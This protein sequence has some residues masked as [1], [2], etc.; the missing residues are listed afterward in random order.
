MLHAEEEINQHASAWAL[1]WLGKTRLW[2]VPAKPDV[3]GRLFALWRTSPDA[4][5]REMA[6]WALTSQT[7][8]PRDEQECCASVPLAELE[9]LLQQYKRLDSSGKVAL[10]LV[11]WYR[12]ALSDVVLIERTRTLLEIDPEDMK[13]P[14]EDERNLLR[15][16]RRKLWRH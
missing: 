12:R 6:C 1:A 4:K 2:T 8:T 13:A 5:V 10:L 16:L 11:A 14:S 7:L 15:E 3:L 9:A